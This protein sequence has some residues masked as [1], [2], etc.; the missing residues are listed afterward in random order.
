VHES[1]MESKVN[2]VLSRLGLSILL[3]LAVIGCSQPLLED[4]YQASDYTYKIGPL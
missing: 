4:V 2:A 3:S 1:M